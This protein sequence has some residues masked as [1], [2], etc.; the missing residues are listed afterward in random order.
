MYK[1]IQDGLVVDVV[2]IPSF[3]RFLKSGNVTMTDKTSAQGVLGSDQQ[4]VYSFKQVSRKDAIVA[5]IE[6]IT[7]EEFSGLKCLLNSGLMAKVDELALDAAKR[8]I[9]ENLSILC[10]TKITNG[11]SVKLSDRKYYDF[12]LTTEDQLN[13][14]SLENQLIN[15]DKTF[16]YHATG[17]LCKVFS[18][19]DMSKIINTF[20]NHTLYHTTYFNAA[21][22]YIYSLS[23]VKQIISFTYGT[24][25]SEFVN[26]VAIKQ[27]L[28]NGGNF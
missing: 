19:E 25:V 21:K 13:L 1:I 20:K 23:D 4:T 15:G 3:I 22:Q 8:I 17:Q 14:L 28:K 5:S 18:R 26:D 7:S 10:K 24:D 12:K 9:I 11:F 6:E 2:R 27:I 16:V